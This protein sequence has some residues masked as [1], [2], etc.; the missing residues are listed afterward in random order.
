MYEKFV[1]FGHQY[2]LLISCVMLCAIWFFNSV[3]IKGLKKTVYDLNLELDHYKKQIKL[4]G[5]D[6]DGDTE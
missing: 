4:F 5:G 3:E 2:G 1:E 6:D